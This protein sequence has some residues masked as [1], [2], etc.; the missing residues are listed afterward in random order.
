MSAAGTAH[1]PRYWVLILVS[2]IGWSLLAAIP[3]TSAYIGTGAAGLEVWWAMF[4]KIGLYYYMWGL[5]TPLIYRLT[6]RLPY[7]GSGLLITVPTHLVVAVVL[8]FSLG[9]LAHKGD[10]YEWVLG[11]RAWG[12]HSMSAFTYALIIL[13]SLAIKF[14]RL[15]LLQQREASD[16]RILAAQLDSKLNLARVDSL[17]MQMNPHFLFNALNSVAALIESNRGERAYQA[18]EQLGDLLRRALNLSQTTDVPLDEELN[19]SEAYLALEQIRFADRLHVDWQIDPATRSLQVPAFILQPLIENAIK[20]AVSRSSRTIQVLVFAALSG[21]QLRLGVSDNG[22]AIQPARS[23]GS[24]GL[25]LANLRERLRLRYG[26]DVTVADG[27][28][29]VGYTTVITMPVSLLESAASA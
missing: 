15:S 24:P 13:C 10:W 27:P 6:D 18:V 7:R 4:K 9:L 25:G 2:F 5:L 22:R 1:S 12:Y 11:R 14:Y 26:S 3:T 8:S 19:F 29:D 16:A 17:R 28:Q 21:D 20:H 23:G